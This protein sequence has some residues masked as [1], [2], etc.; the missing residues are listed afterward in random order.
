MW[1]TTKGYV[2]M[3]LQDQYNH[4]E[5]TLH[6]VLIAAGFKYE[7]TYSYYYTRD[8]EIVYLE[9]F[10]DSPNWYVNG[11]AYNDNEVIE[12]FADASS[13]GLGENSI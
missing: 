9:P 1:Q 4:L 6:K 8:D 11:V 13:T 10:E 12:M 2:V 3:T 7:P 5:S